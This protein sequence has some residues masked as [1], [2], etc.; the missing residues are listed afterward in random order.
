M[1]EDAKGMSCPDEMYV[2]DLLP[3]EEEPLEKESALAYLSRLP[4]GTKLENHFTDCQCAQIGLAN[5]QDGD[6]KK[7]CADFVYEQNIALV[8]TAASSVVVIGLNFVLKTLLVALAA[9]E[10]PL[11]ISGLEQAIAKKVFVALF[12]NTAVIVFILNLAFQPPMDEFLRGHHEDFSHYWYATVGLAV[13]T[14]MAVNVLSP[15]VIS[16]VVAWVGQFKACFCGS[17]CLNTEDS[18][19]TAYDPPPFELAPRCGA[20]LNTIFSTMFFAAGC[21][22]LIFF[23]F[24]NHV[25]CYVCDKYVLLACSKRPP[26]YDAGVI[27]STL[28]FVPIAMLLHALAGIWMFG[29][30]AVFPSDDFL[31]WDL[32][33]T[34]VPQ[35]LVPLVTAAKR[36][37][38]AA[39]FPYF[40]LLLAIGAYLGFQILKFTLGNA[41]APA[42]QALAVVQKTITDAF[43]ARRMSKITRTT[44]RTLR[45][46]D[47][48]KESGATIRH[49]KQ[50]SAAPEPDN[51]ERPSSSIPWD[52]DLDEELPKLQ[53]TAK[54]EEEGTADATV[55]NE[56]DTSGKLNESPTW[57]AA[58]EIWKTSG[59]V[60]SYNIHDNEKYNLRQAAEIDW[61]HF[62]MTGEVCRKQKKEA[63]ANAKEELSSKEDVA[64]S[65]ATAREEVASKQGDHVVDGGS[66]T[67]VVDEK[68]LLRK[69]RPVR[70]DHDEVHGH[71][72]HAAFE[73]ETTGLKITASKSDGGSSSIG[74]T[75]CAVDLGNMS[76]HS[77]EDHHDEV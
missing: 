21:P 76:A 43:A 61:R 15:H 56:D 48:S 11:T 31:D 16:V 68:I 5:L 63:N 38:V 22:I 3:A 73:K 19:V 69:E 42:E 23:A 44:Q 74:I 1:A 6:L 75:M 77:D 35:V 49:T 59:M 2:P 33:T 18:L 72:D 8:I 53:I 66:T 26:A 50:E 29:N 34:G 9:Y 47:L 52:T 30:D 40:L 13:S 39:G 36:A 37:F 70:V 17:C 32:D 10:R 58:K 60:G 65:R 71:D 64:S 14:T 55:I 20:L 27:N 57:M 24:F 12:L 41:F 45:D 62:A 51:S 67:D 46:G 7:A 28:S 4:H 54:Q 25:L